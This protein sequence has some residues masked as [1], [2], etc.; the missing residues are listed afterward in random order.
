MKFPALFKPR[1]PLPDV[2]VLAAGRG[3]RLKHLTATT[4]KP[5]VPV[6]GKGPLMH[7]LG[8][9]AERGFRHVVVNAFYLGEQIEAAAKN[10][11]EGLAVEVL[12]EPELLDTGGG[13]RNALPHLGDGPFMVINGDVIWGEAQTP[14]LRTLVAAFDPARMDALLVLVPHGNAQGYTGAGDFFLQPDGQL[15]WRGTAP[16]APYVYGC[17][18]MMHPRAFRGTQPGAFSVLDVWKAALEAG[19]LFG[20][21]YDGPWVDMGTPEGLAKAERLLTA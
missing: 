5:L 3:T 19:R 12:R 10:A 16:A 15:R 9:L 17:L 6:A 18:Q 21:V 11:P 1:P 7:T 4:P 8:R 14:L 2:M 13:I 20:Y